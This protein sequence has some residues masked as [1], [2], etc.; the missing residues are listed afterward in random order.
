VGERA[1]VPRIRDAHVVSELLERLAS[2][3]DE[4]ERDAEA[5][6]LCTD[7][8]SRVSGGSEN[9]EHG[10][11]DTVR[12]VPIRPKP[13]E[14][15]V[16]LDRSG[17]MTAEA[18]EPLETGGGWTPEHLL[19]AAVARCGANSLSWYASKLEIEVE[20]EAAATGVVERREDGRSAFVDIQCHLDVQLTP[21]PEES[22]LRP[23]LMRAER[24]CFIG[25]SLI[26]HPRY[27]WVV[28][29]KEIS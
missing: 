1:L 14:Y 20:A 23:L 6:R 10:P 19:L 26:A 12:R 15:A 21:L 8:P 25:N 17:V 3:A 9:G 11:N 18:D 16:A 13:K 5:A 28:N 24:G 27:S 22:A 29:G 7:E 2:A 4:P